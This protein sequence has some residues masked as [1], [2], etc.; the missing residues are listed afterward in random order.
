MG[1][2]GQ[3]DNVL[4]ADA[5]LIDSVLEELLR[6]DEARLVLVIFITGSE[7]VVAT[8]APRVDFIT[9]RA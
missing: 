8:H 7:N 3:H 2:C 5:N 6:V 9:L 1:S 4:N